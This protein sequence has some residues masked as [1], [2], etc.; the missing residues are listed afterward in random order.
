MRYGKTQFVKKHNPSPYK[1]A[2]SLTWYLQNMFYNSAGNIISSLRKNLSLSPGHLQLIQL[3]FWPGG[4][5]DGNPFVNTDITLS[6]ARRLKE[7]IL[8]CYYSDIRI[9]RR[10]IAFTGVYEK[11]LEIEQQL[12]ESSRGKDSWDCDSVKYGIQSI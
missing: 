2:V 8:K 7:T 10:R 9:I 5:R 1:E 3:G 6:V 11:L 4:D 12:L